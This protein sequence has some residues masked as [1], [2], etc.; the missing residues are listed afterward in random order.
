MEV[1][2]LGLAAALVFAI[3]VGVARPPR[4]ANH[5]GLRFEVREKVEPGKSEERR[6]DPSL[7]LQAPD[8]HDAQLDDERRVLARS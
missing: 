3:V 6:D 5:A 2:V 1:L 4:N 8:E 7:P